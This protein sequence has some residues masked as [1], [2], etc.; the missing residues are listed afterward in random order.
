MKSHW[1]FLVLSLAGLLAPLGLGLGLMGPV[2]KRLEPDDFGAAQ[3]QRVRAYAQTL[4]VPKVMFVGGSSTFMA[5]DPAS[6]STA[7]GRPVVNYGLSVTTGAEYIARQAS[8]LIRPGDLVV[9][10]AEHV[11]F[12][13]GAVS[14]HGA[15]ANKQKRLAHSP[16]AWSWSMVLASAHGR[17]LLTQLEGPTRA[18]MH[19]SL[20][21]LEHP[22]KPRRNHYEPFLL[23]DQGWFPH[24]RPSRFED[25]RFVWHPRPVK[26]DVNLLKSPGGR[27]LEWLAQVCAERS[28]TLAVM[29]PARVVTP[30]N[31]HDVVQEIERGWLQ[32][33]RELGAIVL[34]EPGEN[35]L[36]L[37]FGF[38]SDY[39]MNDAGAEVIRARL[40][41]ALKKALQEAR[42]R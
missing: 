9:L 14:W 32:R 41:P 42:A 15:P 1:S 2:M 39:H 34:L 38:D 4:D 33:A 27:A 8:D 30:E 20:C 7:V 19:R 17:A 35:A 12:G 37:E 10:A 22:F 36:D 23:N 18:V 13:P 21:G 24:T 26:A 5:I 25:A 6:Y 16:P 40:V 29:P 31:R 11:F 3:E 28:A